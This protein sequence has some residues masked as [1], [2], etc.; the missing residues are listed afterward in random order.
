MKSSFATFIFTHSQDT[1]LPPFSSQ[2]FPFLCS[3]RNLLVS[4]ISLL[5]T[6]EAA[7]SKLGTVAC[8]PKTPSF[9][10]RKLSVLRGR[11]DSF[12]TSPKLCTGQQSHSQ[13]PVRLGQGNVTVPP[14]RLI[15]PCIAWP[16]LPVARIAPLRSYPNAREGGVG[17]KSM[18]VCT[19]TQPA[20][21][22]LASPRPSAWH[23]PSTSAS[24]L[25]L[26][27]AECGSCWLVQFGEGQRRRYQTDLWNSKLFMRGRSFHRCQIWPAGWGL[28]PARACYTY[29]SLGIQHSHTYW[30]TGLAPPC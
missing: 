7:V 21:T 5:L 17:A 10:R 3:N 2:P 13:L 28:V 26:G 23:L 1:V 29:K 15:R 24:Q 6:V 14:A 19:L 27:A 30:V 12:C 9:V 4:V 22:M 8:P 20:P 16:H 11:T 25:H 18:Q